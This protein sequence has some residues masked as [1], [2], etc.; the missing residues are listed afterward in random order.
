M[1]YSVLMWYREN[2]SISTIHWILWGLTECIKI[3]EI[4]L[5]WFEVTYLWPGSDFCRLCADE[6]ITDKE[7]S[8][9]RMCGNLKLLRMSSFLTWVKAPTSDPIDL[10]T[11]D[12]SG[13]FLG[14]T[15]WVGHVTNVLARLSPKL[16]PKVRLPKN[17]PLLC[18]LLV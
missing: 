16:A 2:L 4:W 3:W 1:A 9:W 5:C 13:H 14:L 18:A 17:V 7:R 15:S 8:H 11:G 6:L 10:N 12:L